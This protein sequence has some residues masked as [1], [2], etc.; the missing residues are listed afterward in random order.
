MGRSQKDPLRPFCQEE[1]KLLEQSSRSLT[2]PADQVIHAKEV[3]AV[4]DG[5]TLTD[6]AKLAGRKSG[7]AVA[8]LISRFNR[9]GLPALETRHGGGPPFRDTAVESE[10]LLREC[11]RTPDRRLDGTATGSLVT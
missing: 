8:H 5:H 11:R 1:R 10:R 6:A 3:L 2:M 4:A 9:E 7:D